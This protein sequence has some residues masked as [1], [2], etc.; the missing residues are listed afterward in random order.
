[1]NFVPICGVLK[2]FDSFNYIPLPKIFYDKDKNYFPYI[3]YG[4]VYI[5]HIIYIYKYSS[6]KFRIIKGDLNN[7]I[8]IVWRIDGT[9]TAQY[10]KDIGMLNYALQEIYYH[11]INPHKKKLLLLSTKKD[12]PLELYKQ[13]NNY[14]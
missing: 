10:S 6:V 7:D 12:L 14:L 11:F 8:E 4:K 9:L 3:K 5:C 13:I 2:G 1:M